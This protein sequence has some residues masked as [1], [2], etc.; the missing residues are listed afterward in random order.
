MELFWH[1]KM[2]KSVDKEMPKD[3]VNYFLPYSFTKTVMGDNT[4]ARAKY[5]GLF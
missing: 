1:K 3:K 4:R 5:L 2:S